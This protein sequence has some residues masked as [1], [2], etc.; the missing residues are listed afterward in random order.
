MFSGRAVGVGGSDVAVG[1]W[2]TGSGVS[3]GAG[4]AAAAAIGVLVGVGV[5]S[6]RACPHA[7]RSK[8]AIRRSEASAT[9][10]RLVRCIVFVTRSTE[11]RLFVNSAFTGR[12]AFGRR[13]WLQL[14]APNS[15][16][17]RPCVISSWKSA[18]N[19]CVRRP[20][21]PAAIGISSTRMIGMTSLVVLVINASST[22]ANS[23]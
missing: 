4:A 7:D 2:R 10:E 8:V 15:T 1:N 14:H 16:S 3:V 18:R 6:G 20:G 5:G 23:S 17:I 9:D 11:D 22:I 21:L 19:C 13:H 12:S